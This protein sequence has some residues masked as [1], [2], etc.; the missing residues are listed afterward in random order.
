[1]KFSIF[2]LPFSIITLIFVLGLIYILAPGPTSID[3]FPPIPDSVKSSEPGDTT[4]VPEIAAYFSDYDRAKI[5]EYYKNSYRNKFFF[6]KFLPPVKLSYPPEYA[7][8]LVRD[9]QVSTFLEEYSYPL[10]GSIFVNGY[11]PYV[12][13][14]IK[15]KTHGFVGDHIHIQGRYFVSKTTL[16]FYPADLFGRLIVYLGIWFSIFTFF[17]LSKKIFSKR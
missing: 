17:E 11:E 7:K 1:M 4:Q 12:E 10:K 15:K 2:N 13:N 5:T 9:Q 6:G 16:R 3:D 14:E 8:V